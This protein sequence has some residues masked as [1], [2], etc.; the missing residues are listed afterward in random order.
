MEFCSLSS[1]RFLFF[2]IFKYSSFVFIISTSDDI[3]GKRIRGD[4]SG[5]GVPTILSSAGDIKLSGSAMGDL[6]EVWRPP[7][8]ENEVL[9][10]FFVWFCQ[11]LIISRIRFVSGTGEF[12]PSQR[13]VDAP[14]SPWPIKFDKSFERSLIILL[15]IVLVNTNRTLRVSFVS[16]ILSIFIPFETPVEDFSSNGTRT[17]FLKQPMGLPSIS[18]GAWS[19]GS[20]GAWY[21]LFTN[22]VV[23]NR[24]PGLCFIIYFKAQ[25]NAEVKD[26]GPGFLVVDPCEVA[27]MYSNALLVKSEPR[28]L[29]FISPALQQSKMTRTSLRVCRMLFSA[30]F[31]TTSCISLFSSGLRVEVLLQVSNHFFLSYSSRLLPSQ[32]QCALYFSQSSVPGII[33]NK[34]GVRVIMIPDKFS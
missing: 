22:S 5:V 24:L 1:S 32:V 14:K 29:R 27:A 33:K 2:G 18:L 31:Q 20:L 30:E 3:L 13:M 4:T 9:V 34:Q 15:L 8:L 10:C 25:I 28:T 11:W 19:S 7:E 26:S 23:L 6:G 21:I 17:I 12:M 16:L